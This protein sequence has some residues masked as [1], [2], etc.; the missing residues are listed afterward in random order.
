M[1]YNKKDEKNYD[2]WENNFDSHSGYMLAA[3]NN[4][5]AIL[6]DLILT[7]IAKFDK[8]L[9][10]GCASG[11]TYDWIKEKKLTVTY[12]GTDYSEKFIEA[13]KKRHP[14]IIWEVEDCRKLAEEDGEYD[15]VILYDVLDGLPGW[16]DA[17]DE[18][19]RVAVKKVIVVMWMDPQMEDKLK[20]MQEKGLNVLDMKIEGAIHFHR[21]MVG[22]K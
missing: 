10:L 20:Y 8:V 19:V 13:N 11:G 22:Y 14:N 12:K 21:M 1:K 3:G 16:E 9:D 6:R 5:Y 2:Y 18:A 17:I 15:I 4:E 7:F